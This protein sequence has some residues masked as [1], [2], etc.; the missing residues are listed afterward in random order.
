MIE[1][2]NLVI[3][4]SV[5]KKYNLKKGDKFVLSDIANEKE[6][7]FKIEDIVDYSIGLTVFM[8]IDSMRELFN[9]DE[10]YYNVVLS[11]NALDVEDGRLYSITTKQD[12]E[13][14]SQIFINKM[15]SLIIALMA[16]SLVIFCA[17]MFL[18]LNVMIERA[19]FG[20]SLVK[21]FGFRTGEIRKLY[22]NGN[23]FVVT[24]GAI[25]SIPIAKVIIDL[26]YPNLVANITCGTYIDFS[27]IYYAALFAGIIL[28]YF[29]ISGI[30]T[31]KLNK[32]TPA[33]VLKNR[34]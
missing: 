4:T 34:E 18:M 31:A 14:S 27:P 8:D 2:S 22:L 17:V 21:I 15:I 30:L 20:I 24:V 26:I 25:I 10:D 11:D 1:P 33:D 32:V 12:I 19:S 28:I 5:A 16:V 23:F 13:H 29:V 9:Q 6:Y 3:G 7:A